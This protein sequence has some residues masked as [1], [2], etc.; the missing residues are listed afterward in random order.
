MLEKAMAAHIKFAR[1]TGKSRDR[2][3]PAVL[4]IVLNVK[5]VVLHQSLTGY[6]FDH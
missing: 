2:L 1:L 4:L 3:D 6:N 5:L